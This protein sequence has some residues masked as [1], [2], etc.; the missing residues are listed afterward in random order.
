MKNN[1]GSHLLLH[2]HIKQVEILEYLACCDCGPVQRR[3]EGLALFLWNYNN[4][5][6]TMEL[7]WGTIVPI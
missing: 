4:V 6:C 1:N 5:L 7:D 3:P 2:L